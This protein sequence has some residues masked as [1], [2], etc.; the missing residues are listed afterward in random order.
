MHTINRSKRI[1]TSQ[2]IWFVL[3]LSGSGKSYISNFI[4]QKNNW[5]HLEIDQTSKGDGI[6]LFGLRNEWDLFY[7]RGI[8]EG[9]IEKLKMIYQSAAKEGIVVSFPSRYVIAREQIGTIKKGVKVIY[10]SG[11]KGFCLTSFLQREKETGRNLS[12]TYWQINNDIPAMLIS[13]KSLRAARINVF[14]QTGNYKTTE[15]IFT[16]IVNLD[17]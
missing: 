4:A 17:M 8:G 6:D 16:E 7:H 15:E 13:D 12:S 5:V 10:L 1:S 3:G 2:N 14:T 11:K 9:L